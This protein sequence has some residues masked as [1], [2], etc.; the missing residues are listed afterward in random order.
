VDEGAEISSV[1][2]EVSVAATDVPRGLFSPLSSAVRVEATLVAIESPVEDC[3]LIGKLQADNRIEARTRNPKD[4]R[5]AN[6]S[7]FG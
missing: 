4:F 3:S 2:I 7:L 1:G 5:M 6:I